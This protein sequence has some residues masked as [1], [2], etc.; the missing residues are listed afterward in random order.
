MYAA[1]LLYE[2]Q[3]YAH[4]YCWFWYW[5]FEVILL[6][7][8]SND[9][10]RLS[11]YSM[12]LML[13]SHH[14][15]IS[16]SFVIITVITIE[17]NFR[18]RATTTL[19]GDALQPPYCLFSKLGGSISCSERKAS[20]IEVDW[21]NAF[22]NILVYQVTV[23]PA[24]KEPWDCLGAK[25][26]GPTILQCCLHT[27]IVTDLLFDLARSLKIKPNNAAILSIISCLYSI[28]KYK[29]A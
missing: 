14:M 15:H 28:G 29:F 1:T 5:P 9:A 11:M 21:S 20:K 23:I 12:L 7:F 24:E 22:Q 18:W 25:L 19:L 4:K 3:M 8:E 16:N 13:I 6:K 27:G 2:F 26:R 17:P 10:V